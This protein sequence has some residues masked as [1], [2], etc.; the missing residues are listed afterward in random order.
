M[1]WGTDTLRTCAGWRHATR[2]GGPLEAHDPERGEYRR[3]RPCAG[4]CR[5]LAWLRRSKQGERGPAPVSDASFRSPAACG[6]L[7]GRS[8]CESKLQSPRHRCA[9]RSTEVI[10]RAQ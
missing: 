4:Q 3:A 7:R 8:G 1:L 2:P 5:A 6:R 9:A 10:H